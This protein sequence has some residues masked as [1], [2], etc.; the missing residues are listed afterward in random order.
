MQKN[1]INKGDIITRYKMRYFTV[2]II[3]KSH[4]TKT[5]YHPYFPESI[6]Y[7]LS[8]LTFDHATGIK[9]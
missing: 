8:F 5:I 2:I 4:V 6:Q 9:I 7:I 3:L 1:K